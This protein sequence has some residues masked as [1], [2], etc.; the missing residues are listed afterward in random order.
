MLLLFHRFISRYVRSSVLAQAI[1]LA[2]ALIPVA[3]I[4]LIMLGLSTH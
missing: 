4:A 1:N 2:L 3:G